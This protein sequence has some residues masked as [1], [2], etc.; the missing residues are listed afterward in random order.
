MKRELAGKMS[1]APRNEAVA[2]SGVTRAERFALAKSI[3]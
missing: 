1:R 3:K 2:D